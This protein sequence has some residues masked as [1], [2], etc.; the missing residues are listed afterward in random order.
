MTKTELKKKIL[1]ES[2]DSFV[3]ARKP[4]CFACLS[5]TGENGRMYY[6][7]GFS[8]WSTEDMTIVTK[9]RKLRR[10]IRRFLS[11]PDDGR[12]SFLVEKYMWNEERGI[13]IARGRAIADIIKQ[14][15]DAKHQPSDDFKR[16]SLED[17][18]SKVVI[19]KR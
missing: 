9:S 4:Y 5:W 10:N 15:S 19:L 8:K 17:A 16:Q 6:G 1:E 11:M 3:V 2:K 18:M 13:A 14:V 7:Y 12:D